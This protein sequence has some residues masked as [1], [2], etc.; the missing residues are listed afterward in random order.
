M[1]AKSILFVSALLSAVLADGLDLPNINSWPKKGVKCGEDPNSFE[2]SLDEL[3]FAYQNSPGE[4]PPGSGI[5]SGETSHLGV[6][7]FY[8]IT[9]AVGKKPAVYNWQGAFHRVSCNSRAARK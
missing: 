2:V 7:A 6:F 9:N 5:W 4:H 1:L 8:T 3:K